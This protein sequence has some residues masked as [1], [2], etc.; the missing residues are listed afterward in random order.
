M[1]RRVLSTWTAGGSALAGGLALLFL[2]LV[3]AGSVAE[4]QPLFAPTPTIAPNTAD[5]VKAATPSQVP[6]GGII[7]YTVTITLGSPH[8]VVVDDIF[9]GGG[10]FP[11]SEPVAGSAKLDGNPISDPTLITNYLN[12]ILFR[13]DLGNLDAGVHVLTFQWK[14]NPNLSCYA[15]VKNEA[16]LRLDGSSGNADT[17]TIGTRLLCSVPTPTNTAAPTDTPTPTNTPT[18]TPSPT[19]TPTPTPTDI[20]TNTPTPTDTPSPTD[21]PTPTNTPTETPVPTS[22]ATPTPTATPSGFEPRTIGYWK[23][24]INEATQFLPITVG[25]TTITQAWQVGY[26][27]SANDYDAS[28]ML[29]AQLLAAKLNVSAG[30]DSSCIASVIADADAFL[31]AHP[32]TPPDSP[33]RAEAVDLKDDLDA[34]NN[35]GCPLP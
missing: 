6:P 1:I 8:N 13:F 29:F 31:I 30:A 15:S 9:S 21:T 27:L 33:F 4:G 35:N 22:T 19:D 26:Y 16:H 25:N 10:R 34:Y 20:P 24:H 14:V 3:T 7:D 2:S 12:W 28:K 5:I 18:E 11:D 23:T 32:S 17:F